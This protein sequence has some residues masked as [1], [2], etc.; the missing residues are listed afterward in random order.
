M[1]KLD[2]KKSLYADMALVLVAIIWGSG[3]VVTKNG[4]EDMTPLFMNAMRFIIASILMS[5]VFFKKLKTVNKSDI[6]AGAII[7]SFLFSAFAAQTVGLQFT[8]ASK[9]AFLT[10][11][12]VVMVPFLFW[13]I[14][15]RKPHNLEILATFITLL[16]IGFLTLEG[17]VALN[18][19]DLLTLLCALLF[20]GHIISIGHFSKKH[21]PIVL[22]ILQFIFAA[23]F[24]IILAVP[25]EPINLQVS[26][27]GWFTVIYLGGMSTLVAFLIQNIAQKYTTSTHTAI[28]LSLEAVFGTLFSILLLGELF[29]IKMVIGSGIIFMG[30]IT[31]ETKWNFLRKKSNKIERQNLQ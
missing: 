5:I 16:G 21:D 11:T 18:S 20:A 25:L 14:S 15:K 3:F 10:A 17:G 23:I 27:Q 19:G 1:I 7:G 24:S 8:T 4:L 12:N 28:I 30:I 22:T 31:A 6:I 26:G 13:F 29:T 2:K 9:Q